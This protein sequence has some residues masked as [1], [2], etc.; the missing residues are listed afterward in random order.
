MSTRPFKPVLV[1]TDQG[2]GRAAP[3]LAARDENA[4][5]GAVTTDQGNPLIPVNE[6]NT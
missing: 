4:L 6:I 3:V 5:I 1:A 2:D